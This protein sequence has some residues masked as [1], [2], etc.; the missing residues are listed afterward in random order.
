MT[1]SV[2]DHH[3][4]DS[5]QTIDNRGSYYNLHIIFYFIIILHSKVASFFN[6]VIINHLVTSHYCY[7]PDTYNI[8][9]GVSSCMISKIKN[10]NVL[11]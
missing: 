10:G 11:Q 2:L 6:C 4:D 3:I 1:N 5:A 8:I 7:E 9:C